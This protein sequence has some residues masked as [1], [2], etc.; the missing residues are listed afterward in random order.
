MTVYS[1]GI[2]TVKAGVAQL[3][4][5]IDDFA[6]HNMDLAAQIP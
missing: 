5:L 3:R 6:P 1:L 2:W 4:E